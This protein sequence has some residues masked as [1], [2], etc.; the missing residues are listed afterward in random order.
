MTNI[1]I[2][3]VVKSCR[4]VF[5][6]L[7]LLLPVAVQYQDGTEITREGFV[8]GSAT[9]GGAQLLEGATYGRLTVP[10]LKIGTMLGERMAVLLYAPGGSSMID[11]EERAFEGF[12]PTV[13]YWFTERFYLN[14]GIG[15][16]VETTPFYRVDFTQGPPVFNGGLGF[17]VSAGH[18][19][20]Q[21]SNS[22]TLDVQ[23]RVL[24]GN[25]TYQDQTRKNHLAA[26]LLIG[27][28]FY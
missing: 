26:D 12:F 24:Y 28:N 4:T 7:L 1:T 9:G 10:N 23:A 20:L 19:V 2:K 11:G 17:T 6:A 14:A 27:A 8:F 13:Q 22:N 3:T 25:I 18:E 16:A 5:L 21:W 15:M